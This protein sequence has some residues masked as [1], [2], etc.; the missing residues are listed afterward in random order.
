MTQPK[1]KEVRY[2]LYCSRCKH[3][4]LDD[5]EEPCNTCLETF[6]NSGTDK[7]V[8]YEEKQK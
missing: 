5:F 3:E 4:R 6:F 2:D 1:P 8:N 7:P